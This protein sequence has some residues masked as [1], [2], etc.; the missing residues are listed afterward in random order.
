MMARGRRCLIASNC[1]GVIAAN[2]VGLH[3]A[4]VVALKMGASPA[5]IGALSAIHLC[6][7]AMQLLT[8]QQMQRRGKRRNLIIFQSLAAL[9]FSG[10]VFL[11]DVWDRWQAAHPGWPLAYFMAVAGTRHICNGLAMTGWMPLLQDNVSDQQCGRFF[12]RMRTL[13]QCVMLLWMV[14]LSIWV[15]RDVP[16]SVIRLVFGLGVI[17]SILRACCLMPVHERPPVG[18]SRPLG[19]MLWGPFR[20]RDFR[21]VLVYIVSYGVAIG[22]AEPF[23]AVYLKE[24]DSPDWL[25][26]MGPATVFLGGMVTLTGWGRLVDRW[27]NRACFSISHIGMMV[28]L[29]G[30]LLIDAGTVGFV[31]TFVFFFL[32]GVFNGGNSIAQTNYL[33]GVVGPQ[34][35]AAYF[36]VTTTLSIAA[37]GI[38]GLVG[39]FL[40][41]W[42][43]DVVISQGALSLNAYQLVF[44]LSGLL[45]AVPH[46]VRGRLRHGK[47]ISS[48]EVI[49]F[50]LR[51]VR[52]TLGVLAAAANTARHSDDDE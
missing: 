31:L 9:A 11:P 48:A 34:Q 47:E 30:W 14:V 50:I 42:L 16:W 21:W 10:L 45:F 32:A 33:M 37:I 25:L 24:L 27:G 49:T 38:A 2:I 3:F 7:T 6:S 5:Y 4:T 28:S 36:A 52:M 41:R 1:F 13:V 35:Q 18:E 15:G 23:R 29:F 20:D 46:A 43:E 40:L 17:L 8:M 51:P 26:L 12:G 39:G 19:E 44:L 22:L